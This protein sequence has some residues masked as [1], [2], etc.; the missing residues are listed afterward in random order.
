MATPQARLTI[1]PEEYLRREREAEDRHEYDNGRIYAMAGESPNHSRICINTARETST[2]LKGKSCEAF[3]PNMKVCINAAGKFYYPDL[4]IV[5]GEARY[6]DRE[7]DALLNPKVIIEVLSPSSEK[8]DRSVKFLAYQ[9]V[10]SLADY[11]LVSQDR[12]L[13][14]HFA[15]QDSGQWLYTAHT[16]LSASVHLPSIGCELPLAEIYDR[17]VLPEPEEI[18]SDEKAADDE[19]R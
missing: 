1:S 11:L 5:C 7:R 19:Q 18:E 15:R 4:S 8:R 17:V 2:R 9:Q 10:E 13:V 12:L 14:E 16:D 3:S 6:H